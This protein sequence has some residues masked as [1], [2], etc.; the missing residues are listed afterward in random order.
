MRSSTKTVDELNEEITYIAGIV[1]NLLSL[2]GTAQVEREE[3]DINEMIRNTMGLLRHN[4]VDK[5]ISITFNS[6]EKELTLTVNRN[7]IKQVILNLVKNSFEAMP[8]GGDIRIDTS[9]TTDEQGRQCAAIVFTDSGPGIPDANLHNV[10]I[11]FY[12]TR[13][14]KGDNVG[15]GLSICYGIVKRHDGTMNVRNLEQSGCQF[16]I[17]LPFQVNPD[18]EM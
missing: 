8:S 15:L 11:P 13:K 1:Q 7:E 4:A 12:S 2:S 6:S 5:H 17:L 18:R 3:I 9:R 10:F 14:G 16:T